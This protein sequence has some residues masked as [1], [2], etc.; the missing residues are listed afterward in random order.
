M[1]VDASDNE[2]VLDVDGTPQHVAY[3]DITNARTVFDWEPQPRP[4]SPSKSRTRAK[5][6]A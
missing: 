6:R 2:I 4:G 3:A 5:E 1:L